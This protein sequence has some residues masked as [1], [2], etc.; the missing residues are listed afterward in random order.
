V[1]GIAFGEPWNVRN[2]FCEPARL[3]FSQRLDGAPIEGLV[4]YLV[5]AHLL[6]CPPCK[7]TYKA[8]AATRDALSALRDND[9]AK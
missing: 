5:E 4:R 3:H 6:I 9:P 1:E 8:L 2:R 7:R